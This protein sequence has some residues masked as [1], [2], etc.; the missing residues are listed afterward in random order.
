[1]YNYDDDTFKYNQECDYYYFSL[2]C[3]KMDSEVKSKMY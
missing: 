2:D 3:D 1:M